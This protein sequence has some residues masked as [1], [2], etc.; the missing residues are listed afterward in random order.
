MTTKE[1]DEIEARID[2]LPREERR[3]FKSHILGWCLGRFWGEDSEDA[4]AFWNKAKERLEMY[5]RQ[6]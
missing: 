3:L 4:N 2:K 5:E 6:D 1:C